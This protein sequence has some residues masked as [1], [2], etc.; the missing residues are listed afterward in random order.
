MSKALS[1][2]LRDAGAGG[3][4]GGGDVTGRRRRGSGSARRASA[5]G[6]RGSARQGESGPGRWAAIAARAGSR[7]M[8]ALILGAAGGRRRTSRSRSCARRLAERGHR[9][10]LRHAAA[11]LRPPRHH[12]QKKTAHA[13]EQDRP[14]VLKR[15]RG[16][17]RGPARPRSRAPGLHRRDLG[18]DQHGPAPRPRPARRAP[19]RRRAARPLEDHHLRRRA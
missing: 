16:L 9:L 13:T 1:V 5:A 11:L 7:R 2:D 17:V 15:R 8:R 3:G 14:D 19:A 12:A 6:A 18:H 10:R 4:C